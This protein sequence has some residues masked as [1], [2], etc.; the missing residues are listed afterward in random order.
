MRGLARERERESE[1]ERASCWVKTADRLAASWRF[2]WGFAMCFI[3]EVLGLGFMFSG[4]CE[5]VQ[6]EADFPI[7]DRGWALCG[8]AWNRFYLFIYYC[9]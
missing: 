4:V 5:G 9:C 3:L 6:R 2:V 7:R 8:S 1:S